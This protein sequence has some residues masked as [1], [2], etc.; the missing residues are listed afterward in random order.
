MIHD[1]LPSCQHIMK[2]DH[3]EDAGR[4]IEYLTRMLMQDQSYKFLLEGRR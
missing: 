1:V 2:H 4:Q 3:I